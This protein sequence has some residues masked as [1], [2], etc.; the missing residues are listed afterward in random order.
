[1]LGER[2]QALDWEQVAADAHPFLAPG[3]DPDLLTLGNALRVLG[4]AE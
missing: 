3:T 1:V 2:V 4:L